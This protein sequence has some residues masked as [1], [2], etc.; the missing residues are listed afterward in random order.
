[1][2]KI[3]KLPKNFNLLDPKVIEDP[4]EAYSVYRE[5]APVFLSPDTG[6]YVVTKY[7]DL[8]R[9]LSDY[10]FFSRDIA[11]YWEKNVEKK[12][13][14]YWKYGRSVGKVFSEKGWKQVPCFGSE[15]PNHTRFRKAANPSFTAGRIKK[16]EPYIKNLV[17]E[18][19]DTFIDDG[20]VEFISQF[21]VPLPMNVIQ[22][23]LG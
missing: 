2:D 17:N 11:A 15:P 3:E 10:D 20:K 22:D 9:V 23:R 19:I 12:K 18:L 21:C 5:K 7:E 4:Y 8:K 6:F 14:G 1:M 16:M 13:E